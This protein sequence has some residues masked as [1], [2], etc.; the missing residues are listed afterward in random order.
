MRDR[1]SSSR[2]SAPSVPA[3]RYRRGMAAYSCAR[4][5][6]C[7]PSAVRIRLMISAFAVFICSPSKTWSS[8]RV[9]LPVPLPPLAERFGWHRRQVARI[10]PRAERAWQTHEAIA[11]LEWPLRRAGE[12]LGDRQPRRVLERERRR[13]HPDPLAERRIPLRD[14]PPQVNQDL[15][16][17]DLDGAHLVARA[18]ERRRV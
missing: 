3:C 18:A 12:L 11:L 13:L 5:S 9:F 4:V 6:A 15:R 1:K 17:V 8:R 14:S 10:G 16:D 2:A 7:V